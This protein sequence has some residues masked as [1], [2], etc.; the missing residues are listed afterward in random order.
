MYIKRPAYTHVIILFYKW[1][2]AY[3]NIYRTPAQGLQWPPGVPT[4]SVEQ[5]FFICII[6][7]RVQEN[8][9]T[10]TGSN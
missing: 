1:S 10:V 6:T 3:D 2:R 8:P 5:L 4:Y 9:N 7:A